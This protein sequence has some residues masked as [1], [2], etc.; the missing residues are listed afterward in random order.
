MVN[1]TTTPDVDLNIQNLSPDTDFDVTSIDQTGG[2]AGSAEY[3]GWCD[4]AVR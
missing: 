3:P 1:Q 4:G 2:P